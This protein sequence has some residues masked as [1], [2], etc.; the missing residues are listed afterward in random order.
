ML[1]GLSVDPAVTPTK[2]LLTRIMT[3][4]SCHGFGWKMCIHTPAWTLSETML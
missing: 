3:Q 4:K 1:L 2:N